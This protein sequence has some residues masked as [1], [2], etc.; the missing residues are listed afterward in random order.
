MGR[1]FHRMI[2]L[3]VDLEFLSHV[4]SPRDAGNAGG[5]ASFVQR[6]AAVEMR[7]VYTGRMPPFPV[8]LDYPREIAGTKMENYLD[9]MKTCYYVTITSH[10]AVSVPAGFTDDAV[11]LPV[12]LQIVGRYRDDFGVLQLAH[13]F[14][15]ATQ[16]ALRRPAIAV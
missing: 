10:P 8:D 1:M 5:G 2:V 3:S 11:P 14:E 13:A 12:G 15:E 16:V 7:M 4:R 6:A 9:W